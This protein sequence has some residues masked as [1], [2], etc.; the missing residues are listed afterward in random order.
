M[1]AAANE[2]SDSAPLA[3]AERRQRTGERRPMKITQQDA[4]TFEADEFPWVALIPAVLALPIIAGV[5]VYVA[6]HDWGG[7]FRTGLWLLLPLLCF[8]VF[9]KRT[10][11]KADRSSGMLTVAISTPIS[12]RQQEVRIDEIGEV[13][14]EVRKRPRKAPSRMVWLTLKDG[15]LVPL[16][17][18]RSVGVSGEALKAPAAALAA[19]LGIPLRDVQS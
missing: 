2:F 17:P 9:C 1:L 4:H 5:I 7:A 6:R 13:A 18:F 11:V 3:R 15:S 12:S 8:V 16:S 19:W 14:L 10:R